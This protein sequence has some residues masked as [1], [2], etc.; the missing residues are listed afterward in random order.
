MHGILYTLIGEPKITLW[1]LDFDTLVQ[2]NK[3]NRTTKKPKQQEEHD[4]W[5]DVNA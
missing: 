1:V 3:T 2:K 4:W 5:K